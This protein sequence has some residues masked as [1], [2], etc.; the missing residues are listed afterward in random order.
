LIDGSNKNANIDIKIWEK[1]NAFRA[2]CSRLLHP[3]TA[4]GKLW[5]SSYGMKKNTQ[6]VEFFVMSSF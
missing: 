1:E 4:L 2:R 5:R 6:I 3:E